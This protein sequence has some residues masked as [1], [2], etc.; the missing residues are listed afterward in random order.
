MGVKVQAC[1][2]NTW[3]SIQ[4][5]KLYTF[6]HF[7]TSSKSWQDADDGERRVG[8]PGL[9]AS[10]HLFVAGDDVFNRWFAMTP[11]LAKI[12]DAVLQDHASGG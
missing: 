5:L 8:Q 7:E 9:D 1:S 10:D 11:Q 6:G 3:W 2:S 12:V 4:K